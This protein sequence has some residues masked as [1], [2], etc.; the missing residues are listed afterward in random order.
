MALV[1]K[2]FS[3]IIT[4]TRAS[5]ATYFN[6]AGVLTSAATNAPRF[7]YNPSTL[8]AQGLLI[9]E[10][11]ANALTYSE[12]LTNA[13]WVGT[14][15]TVSA[16]STTSPAGTTTADTLIATTT[17]AEHTL[18]QSFSV[19]SGTTYT[20]TAFVK[21]AGLTNIGLRFTIGALWTG[22]S[23]PQIGFDLTAVSTA[24]IGGSPASSSI[25]NVGN[26]YYRISMSVV[27]VGTGTAS[28]RLQ[29]MSGV[30]NTFAGNGTSG[31][32]V[33]GAQV[34]AGA[35]PTSYI[36]TTTTALTRAADVASVNTLSPWYNSVEGTLYGEFA[37]AGYAP[38]SSFSI[39]AVLSDNTNNNVISVANTN[40]GAN[41]Y[42][43]GEINTGGVSQ[44]GFYGASGLSFGV[45]SVR[46]SAIAY[47]ANNFAF[48][49]QGAAVQTDT[50]GTVP[51]VSRLYVGVGATGG[52]L[53]LNGYLRRVSY[54]PTRL[55]NA[56][57]QAITA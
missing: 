28:A 48:T 34:E 30:N 33:W 38:T 18:D 4:F 21:A 1:T 15:V 14:N 7:D 49:T 25:T 2:N 32:Y 50:S 3:D 17:N 55:S 27:A 41:L 51:T 11:R 20:F 22:G 45:G 57:L 8:A 40:T 12:D 31:V 10:S 16:N 6:S 23:S 46:K 26:G 19:T 53:F 39:P 13:A 42:S 43:Y 47:A 52:S 44:A 29:L 56:Q 35:F 5:T 9:E 37:V 24:V 54:Y 36:P